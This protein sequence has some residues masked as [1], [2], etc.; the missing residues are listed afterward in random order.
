MKKKTVQI[1]V[2]PG[3]SQ[4]CLLAGHYSVNGKVK[5]LTMNREVLNKNLSPTDTENKRFMMEFSKNNPALTYNFD[6]TDIDTSNALETALMDR[7]NAV[8]EFWA[9]HP[10]IKPT[11]QDNPN[12]KGAPSF[13]MSIKESNETKSYDDICKAIEISNAFMDMKLA[14]Q[15]DM[16]YYFGGNPT[17]MSPEQLVIDMI[18]PNVGRI[19]KAENRDKFLK[20]IDVKGGRMSVEIETKRAIA[21]KVI[22]KKEGKYF[23]PSGIQIGLTEEDCIM[24]MNTNPTDLKFITEQAKGKDATSAAKIEVEAKGAIGLQELRYKAQELHIEGAYILDRDKLELEIAKAESK[25]AK[26]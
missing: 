12:L 14:D 25:A 20:S 4:N 3:L 6:W 9:N 8:I 17:E 26:K 24:Y 19:L 5:T 23:L 22:E 15:R 18:D 11:F 1:V 2:A 21:N 16:C 7:D 13:I 10:L